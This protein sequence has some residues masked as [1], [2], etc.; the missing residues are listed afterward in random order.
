MIMINPPMQ[1]WYKIVISVSSCSLLFL[2]LVWQYVIVCWP[3]RA[4]VIVPEWI[5][6]YIAVHWQFLYCNK[7][8]YY[9]NILMTLFHKATHTVPFFSKISVKS[10]PKT[11]SK[12][13]KSH[14]KIAKSR[15][16]RHSVHKPTSQKKRC[17]S[18]LTAKQTKTRPSDAQIQ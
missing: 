14:T 13:T 12:H 3:K 11:C 18:K 1:D 8:A 10:N 9:H 4:E 2:L 5:Y 6:F 16:K 7:S 15:L 17:H